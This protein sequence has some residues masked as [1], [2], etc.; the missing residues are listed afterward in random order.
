MLGVFGD[1]SKLEHLNISPDV[2][3]QDVEHVKSFREN[4][5]PIIWVPKTRRE[6]DGVEDIDG[7][8]YL[9]AFNNSGCI[10]RPSII[11]KTMHVLEEV[12]ALGY[13][14][15]MLDAVRLP[16]P[17]DG[18]YFITTCF[19]KHSIELYPELVSLR[20]TVRQFILK[21]T[22]DMLLHL[23]EELS[24]ARMAHVENFLSTVSDKARQLGIE[25]V[26]AVFPD[27]LSRYVGQYPQVLK[28]YLSE[29]HVM[30][31]HKC[32]GAACLNAETKALVNLLSSMGLDEGSIKELILKLTGLSVEECGRS[33]RDLGEEIPI[34]CLETLV[35]KNKSIYGGLFV[36]IL[37]L[38][39]NI[40]CKLSDYLKIYQDVDLFIP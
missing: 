15:L 8:H 30:F 5:I 25:L 14:K 40:T 19:C 39:K 9:F 2:V 32:N 7:V 29:V 23:L 24:T 26:A 36:P 31:Y 13:S 3:Y 34:N 37:W 21:P 17:I 22:P 4:I 16:S 6:A 1:L 10:A 28:K 11:E 33:L 12:A 18:K 38:D 20:N 35:R 27:P